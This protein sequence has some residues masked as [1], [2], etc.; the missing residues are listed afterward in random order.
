MPDVKRR[1]L[2]DAAAASKVAS[3]SAAKKAKTS[4]ATEIPDISDIHFHDEKTD[5]VPVFD[6]ADEIRKKINAHLK[7]PGLT[8]AQFCRDLFAQLQAPTCKA[9]Q[10]KQ[11]ADFRAKKGPLSGCTSSVCYTAYVLFEKIRL[12]KGKP[13]SAHRLEMEKAHRGGVDRTH[14][15]RQ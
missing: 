3:G 8:Q 5:N 13:K 10:S 2:A 6:S 11:L 14:D 4:A 1:Q 7:T 9:I 12:A 15:G